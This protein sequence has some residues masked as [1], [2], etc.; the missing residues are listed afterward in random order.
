MTSKFPVMEKKEELIARVRDAAKHVA[1]GSGE[2][3]E[4]A[5]QR[6][7][8]SPQCGFASHAEGN[9][10]T[11]AD[12]SFEP[13]GRRFAATPFAAGLVLTSLPSPLHLNRSRPSSPSVSRSPRLS[14][15]PTPKRALLQPTAASRSERRSFNCTSSGSHLSQSFPI[16]KGLNRSP[17]AYSF[18][19]H[20]TQSVLY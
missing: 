19:P 16:S 14:G 5:L 15:P 12:V 8:I 13:L 2:T 4:Q 6:L 3:E 1:R 9:D 7:C 20:S 17:L 10:M 11:D 18:I